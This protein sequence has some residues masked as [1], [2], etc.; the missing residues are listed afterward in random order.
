MLVESL[1]L[2]F[3]DV[4]RLANVLPELAA[5]PRFPR[6]SQ[7]CALFLVEPADKAVRGFLKFLNK[8]NRPRDVAKHPP[9]WRRP[10]RGFRH[11]RQG[12]YANY[13]PSKY[14][15]YEGFERGRPGG[16]DAAAMPPDS[17]RR[18]AA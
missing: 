17:P 11:F 2:T 14:E 1:A 10:A 16:G 3:A 7:S 12:F 18:C 6:G 4:K 8:V 5:T 13:A 15:K 9:G